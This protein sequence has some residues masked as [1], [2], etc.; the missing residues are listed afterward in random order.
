M[1]AV[2]TTF[3]VKFDEQG[4]RLG[5]EPSVTQLFDGKAVQLDSQQRALNYITEQ[6]S[7]DGQL[8]AG[9]VDD[10]Q[11]VM[12]LLRQRTNFITGEVQESLEPPRH[13]SK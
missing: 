10:G 5:V 2:A 3:K 12:T 1:L 4:Q 8:L 7:P 11:V 6:E 9:L 13:F